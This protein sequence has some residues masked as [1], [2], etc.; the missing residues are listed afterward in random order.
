[1]FVCDKRDRAITY[2]L[3][4][5]KPVNRPLVE[6]GIREREKPPFPSLSL[7]FFSPDREPVHRLCRD[8]HSAL[9][10]SGFYKKI[11]LKESDSW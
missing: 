3:C 11:C 1:M 5:D 7:L 8:L 2:M 6:W 10:F 9:M 4:R